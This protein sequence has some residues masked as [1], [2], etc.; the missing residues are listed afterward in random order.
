M[1]VGLRDIVGLIAIGSIGYGGWLVGP[2]LAFMA[3]GGSLL[4]LTVVGTIWG[5]PQPPVP[6]VR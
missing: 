1:T 2:W 4:L 5:R 3:A 6:P